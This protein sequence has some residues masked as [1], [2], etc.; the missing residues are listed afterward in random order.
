MNITF[1]IGNGFDLNLG[2]NTRYTDMYESYIDSESDNQVIEKFKEDLK[3]DEHN[4][5]ENWSDFEMGMANYASKFSYEDDFIA[6]IRDF[7]AHMVN[8]LKLEEEHYNFNPRRSVDSLWESV[9]TFH[10]GSTPNVTYTLGDIIAQDGRCNCNFITFNYTHILD[11]IIDMTSKKRNIQEITYE[12]KQVIHIHG[13][14]NN[15]VVLGVNAVD[16]VKGFFAKT[17]K[18][19]LAFIKPIFN[20]IYD[21][22]RVNQ[23]INAIASSSIVCAFGL[24][25]G[26]SDKCWTNALKAWLLA[27]ESHHLVFYVYNEEEIPSYNFDV[28]IEKEYELK[29]KIFQKMELVQDEIKILE[30]RIHVPINHSIFKFS[31]ELN[32]EELATV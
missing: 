16:Q 26:E 30:E 23:A 32:V 11:K 8:H 18:T 14:L 9:K 7:K 22:R 4:H 13:D 17:R 28:R 3:K 29:N 24:S 1:L 12:L 25:L 10:I 6:C 31:S 27:D 21:N 5:Y 19:E 15:D 20:S 2:L